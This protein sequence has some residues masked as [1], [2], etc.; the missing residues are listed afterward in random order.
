MPRVRQTDPPAALIVTRVTP[1]RPL[2]GGAH[3][4]AQQC[5][6]RQRCRDRAASGLAHHR[7]RGPWSLCRLGGFPGGAL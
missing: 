5:D 1:I 4:L 6:R 3:R 7:L 2:A